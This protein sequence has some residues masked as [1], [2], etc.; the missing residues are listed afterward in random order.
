MLKRLFP[1][2]TLAAGMQMATNSLSAA[3]FTNLDCESNSCPL[4]ARIKVND[5]E[6]LYPKESPDL[7]LRLDTRPLNIK[8]DENKSFRIL[9]YTVENNQNKILS[10][11]QVRFT[12]R[13]KANL[14][15]K[16]KLNPF[17]GDRKI[18]FAIHDSN[19]NL[20]STYSTV[21]TGSGQ[22]VANNIQG[23]LNP[24]L[25]NLG[26]SD[27]T[28]TDEAFSECKVDEFFFKKF[29][30]EVDN[31]Q[32]PREIVVKK[33]ED[34]TYRLIVP[35]I[36]S[37]L[38]EQDTVRTRRRVRGN[39]AGGGNSGPGLSNTPEEVSVEQL[40]LGSITDNTRI[41][42]NQND[43][44]LEVSV[45]GNAA[46]TADEDANLA[47][48]KTDAQAGVEIAATSDQQVPVK[49]VN[50]DLVDTL[51]DGAFEYN[52]GNLFFTLGGVRY[53]VVTDP[54]SPNPTPQAGNPQIPNS[55]ANSP[56][57]NNLNNQPAAFYTNAS[58]LTSGTLDA[59]RLPVNANA[60]I[61]NNIDDNTYDLNM[62]GSNSVVFTSTADT[63]LTFPANSGT[64]ATEQDLQVGNSA[65]T[66]EVVVDG[67]I[68]TQDVETAGI[69]AD[70]ISSVSADKFNAGQ[71]P[72]SVLPNRDIIQITGLQAAL[73]AKIN[74]SDVVDNVTTEN[75]NVPL[76]AN[77]G[78]ILDQQIT[79]INDTDIPA[80]RVA[81]S[82]NE[83]DFTLFYTVYTASL[84]GDT[85]L[86]A[87]NI[88]Q[89]H[90][91]ILIADAANGA[92]LNL[93]AEVEIVKG[94]FQ[95][96]AVNIIELE[97]ISD[98][99][100]NEVLIAKINQAA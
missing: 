42:T 5:L 62:T 81:L 49:F 24:S 97:V 99:T 65:V 27:I 61:L 57:A 22:F 73:D 10:S 21:V 84:N 41:A 17:I 77:Q 71:V 95:A 78:Y 3:R 80:E 59:A 89:G 43:L 94:N 45:N 92:S 11:T 53:F 20:V 55:V 68:Q 76:S 30:V 54:N 12:R 86:T 36:Q 64:I 9:A 1:I 13:R 28:C 96:D 29:L 50:S 33:D 72:L 85:T 37:G 31:R 74:Q 23:G 91:I 18:F 69:V 67:T 7:N 83:L 58:N 44:D 63:A 100:G 25:S 51:Q 46:F 6:K 93:P 16:V 56:N 40:I 15:V 47:L 32:R 88:K 98:A 87:S 38:G 35:F 48:G 90:K 60:E 34:G 4:N 26:E 70:D 75:A 66:T 2:I 52:N 82:N 14:N 79:G 39:N 8:Q 19:G